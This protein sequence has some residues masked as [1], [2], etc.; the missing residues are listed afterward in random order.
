MNDIL[1][2]MMTEPD[3]SLWDQIKTVIPAIVSSIVT[4]FFAWFLTRKRYKA[5]VSG[6]EIENVDGAVE[7]W[8]KLATDLKKELGDVKDELK[9]FKEDHKKLHDDNLE[10]Q[11]QIRELNE[12]L[13]GNS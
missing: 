9:Q 7:I 2:Q 3:P 10:L 12:K 6:L 13:N 11:G 1:L 5:E 8:R 4:G